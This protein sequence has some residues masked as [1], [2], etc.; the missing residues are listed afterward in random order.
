MPCQIHYVYMQALGG[1]HRCCEKEFPICLGFFLY[2][3][4]L[5]S[6]L[7]PQCWSTDDEVVKGLELASCLLPS[8]VLETFRSDKFLR[9]FADFLALEQSWFLFLQVILPFPF[10]Y[11]H[12]TQ[13]VLFYG[14]L[15]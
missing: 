5:M 14:F 8:V 2:S 11:L 1:G 3:Q 13:P 7:L 15:F 6:N 12:C 10:L 4:T 9:K